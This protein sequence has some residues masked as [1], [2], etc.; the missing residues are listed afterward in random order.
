MPSKK[1]PACWPLATALTVLAFNRQSHLVADGLAAEQRDLRQKLAAVQVGGET[2][3]DCA[4]PDVAAALAAPARKVVFFIT[5]GE[6]PAMDTPRWKALL[7]VPD[8]HLFIL[9]P[10]VA[11]ASPPVVPATSPSVLQ[12]LASALPNAV[13]SHTPDPAAWSDTLCR[14]L[15]DQL[16]GTFEVSPP[17]P[18]LLWS[19]ADVPTAPLAINSATA[20][21]VTWL[22]P[23]SLLLAGELPPFNT[24]GGNLTP[25]AAIAQ[26]GLGKVAAITLADLSS[27]PAQ[28]LLQRALYDVA[29]SPGDRRFFRHRPP[30]E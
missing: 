2:T 11:S 28:S 19:R 17:A 29:P 23:E 9:A 8:T 24:V 12:Q 1:P 25:V 21:T 20:W 27:P 7:A 16:R 22:K 13:W 18:P 15:A 10:P 4:L 14:L 5:D 6:I 3:P 30:A 26:R